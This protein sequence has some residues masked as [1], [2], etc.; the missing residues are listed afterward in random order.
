MKKVK[1][2]LGPN[3]LH[4]YVEL[5]PDGS[6][7]NCRK[8]VSRKKDIQ[9]AL[10]YDQGGICAYCEIDLKELDVSSSNNV[11]PDFRVEHFHPKSDNSTA[12][13]WNLDW[14]NLLACCN[15]GSPLSA[16]VVVT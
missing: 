3:S 11:V 1:K 5:S 8:N 2:G 16:S 9:D 13:N 7:T 6:W 12:H 4:A 14:N 10:K 15:G